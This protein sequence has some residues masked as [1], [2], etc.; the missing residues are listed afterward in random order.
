MR[1]R[2]HLKK[3]NICN[4]TKPFLIFFP[5]KNTSNPCDCSTVFNV[6]PLIRKSFTTSLMTWHAVES[7]EITGVLGVSQGGHAGMMLCSMQRCW[8]GK[9]LG[10]L[11]SIKNMWEI[12]CV[13][14]KCKINMTYMVVKSHNVSPQVGVGARDYM[15]P[16]KTWQFAHGNGRTLSTTKFQ[17]LC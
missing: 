11:S 17:G 2:T 5:N 7:T 8:F 14:K 6:S 10:R 1:P 9:N 3:Q 12:F 15:Y 4:V 13:Y 16:S